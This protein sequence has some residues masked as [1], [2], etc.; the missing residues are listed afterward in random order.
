MCNVGGRL[1]LV[2]SSS[3]TILLFLL[4][5]KTYTLLGKK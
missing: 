1:Y 4:T 5:Y 3:S 2:S